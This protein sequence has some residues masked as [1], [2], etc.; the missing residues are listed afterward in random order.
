MSRNGE[1]Y[2]AVD[3][4]ERFPGIHTCRLVGCVL[5]KP[6]NLPNSLTVLR[7]LLIPFF[8]GFLT[9]GHYQWA[10]W[11]LL[12]AGVTDILD[13]VIARMAN[14]RTKLGTYLD[15]LADKLLLTSAF[16][17]LSVLHLVPGWVAIVVVSRDLI[18][19]AGT[20]LLHVTQTPIEVVPTALG[21]G[22]TLVQLSYLVLALV[23]I[24]FQEDV[25]QLMPLLI[26]MLTLTIV[27]GLQY[28]Y[29]G[30]RAYHPDL[31]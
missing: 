15:P 14:Q 12:V 4:V 6:M 24:A 19:V 28:V 10:L 5:Q 8:I 1:R 22:T 11:T 30:I 25:R 3:G 7:I 21:K 20:L 2:P 18:I 26:L 16:V 9:Y 29:R 23:L 13:G 17:T 27:S 31:V